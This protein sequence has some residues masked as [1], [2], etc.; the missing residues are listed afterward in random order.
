MPLS[1]PTE[2]ALSFLASAQLLFGIVALQMN[3]VTREQLVAA[4]DTWTNDKSR[5]LAEILIGSGNLSPEDRQLLERLV[6]RFLERHG[7]DPEKSLAALSPVEGM[8]PA[9]ECFHDADLAAS[10][11]LVGQG[12]FTEPDEAATL[13]V[14][15]G[16]SRGRFRIL[17][18][19]AKGGLGQVSVA[20]D[21]DLN[22]E[23]ALKEIQPEHADNPVSRERFLLEA[24]ITGG[25]EHPGIV[26]VY[27]LGHGADGRPFYAMRLI[28]GD[29]L[30]AAIE[31]Y[32]RPDNPNRRD[33]GE[34]QLDLRRLLDRFVDVCN[35][36]D[37]A[38]SRGVLHRDLKPGNIM[39]GK[40]GETLVVD[41]GL[42][43]AVGKKEIISDEATLAPAS[44]ISSSGQTQPGSAIGT[45]AYMSPEQAAG[46]LDQLGPTSDVYS[47][48]ATLYQILCGNPPFEKENL[49]ETLTKVQRGDFPKP[50]TVCP[51]IPGGLEAICLKAM[52]VLPVE[53]YQT[54]RALADDLE[55]WLADEPIVAAPDTPA[56]RIN[57]FARKHRGA[58]LA[59]GIVCVVSLAAM[60]V[61]NDQRHETNRVKLEREEAQEDLQH[62]R[63]VERLVLENSR[64]G[65]NLAL[66][67]V[68]GVPKPDASAEFL[69]IAEESVASWLVGASWIR[70]GDYERGIE[71]LRRN[72][73]SPS[74]PPSSQFAAPPGWNELFIALAES[75]LGMQ[76]D[77]LRS[78]E[79]AESRIAEANST[80]AWTVWYQRAAVAALQREV[81]ELLKIEIRQS[82]QYEAG[83]SACPATK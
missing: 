72:S 32:H 58:M 83:Q 1:R 14:P 7:G 29:S 8:R 47:L 18:P 5:T 19:H 63:A 28:R 79:A 10:L 25:L 56:E 77:A 76:D 38:H 35:A 73:G 55:R 23:V 26:P 54:V 41:W 4:F 20:L 49:A 36:V 81:A 40:H 46:K 53:R 13:L 31:A 34:R 2:S 70:R 64:L 45:P 12:R 82:P 16:P 75:H 52:S 78:Y 57:R 60:L 71:A 69:R 21:Q 66:A 62:A 22:R 43:K 3:F 11:G 15:S 24:E 9:L 30:K 51:T 42:A 44:A 48:G 80:G 50:R 39:V 37:Y 61:I 68:A 59:T 17:R 74:A 6:S 65:R 27:A 33:P 67:F